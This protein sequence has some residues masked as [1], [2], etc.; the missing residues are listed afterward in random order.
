M[1]VLDSIPAPDDAAGMV[2][3]SADQLWNRRSWWGS[4]RTTALREASLARQH[5]GEKYAKA[6]TAGRVQG[7]SADN[8]A[9]EHRGKHVPFEVS[10]LEST[11]PHSKEALL[12]NAV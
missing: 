5:D 2:S 4:G 7:T 12:T 6:S 8:T 3:N 11:V 9:R 1:D 10:C